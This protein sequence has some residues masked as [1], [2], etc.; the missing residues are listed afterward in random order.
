MCAIL[1]LTLQLTAK[2]TM[3][4]LS[5]NGI[6]A[7]IQLLLARFKLV[8]G[9]QE[10]K[11]NITRDA[12]VGVRM[13]IRPNHTDACIANETILEGT[14]FKDY[15]ADKFANLRTI[16][17][18]GANIGAFTIPA[19]ALAKN[20]VVYAFEPENS[21]ADLLERN[22]ILNNLQN[23]VIERCCVGAM[24]DECVLNLNRQ[25]GSHS[26]VTSLDK[27][28]T[29]KARIISFNGFMETMPRVDFLKMDCEGAEYQIIYSL[30]KNNLDKIKYMV[31][32][33]HPVENESPDALA[34]Y[35][36]QNG[37][38]ITNGKNTTEGIWYCRNKK[39]S[40]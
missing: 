11:F 22:T 27:V 34:N 30:K 6:S 31:M 17:D 23:I 35:L 5:K 2:S 1:L 13:F 21:N 25:S 38:T 4:M 28:G 32:E 10:I 8:R 14:Y 19:A 29:Q 20:A 40:D 26:I 36:R 33:C 37:F 7:T 9:E 16:V 24:D 39:I 18:I 12:S 15:D 3:A